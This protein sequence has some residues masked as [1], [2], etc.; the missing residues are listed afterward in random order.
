LDD[1]E[2]GLTEYEPSADVKIKPVDK[3][4]SSKPES[5]TTSVPVPEVKAAASAA[6][7]VK[8]APV[9]VAEKAVVKPAEVTTQVKASVSVSATAQAQPV[10]TTADP[11]PAPVVISAEAK[12]AAISALGAKKAQRAERF[13]I[14]VKAVVIPDEVKKEERKARFG[15]SDK[16]GNDHPKKGAKEVIPMTEEQ[17]VCR[18]VAC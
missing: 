6:V 3:I 11:T 15:T 10:A 2:F 9:K 4:I 5:T 17:K 12:A 1:E 8:S 16:E 18:V 7:E 14:P 13:G